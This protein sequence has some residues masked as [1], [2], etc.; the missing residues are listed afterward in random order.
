MH[1]SSLRLRQLVPPVATVATLLAV[2]IGWW[3]P[4]AFVVPVLYLAAVVLSVNGALIT[5]LLALAIAPAMH[6][7]WSLGLFIGMIRSKAI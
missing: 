2:V 7:S 6:F 1:S 3:L 5:R 4:I